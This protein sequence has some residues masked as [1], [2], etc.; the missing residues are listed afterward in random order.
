MSRRHL[1]N[2]RKARQ[3]AWTPFDEKWSANDLATT[4]TSKTQD[5]RVGS[6]LDC[7]SATLSSSGCNS[8]FNGHGPNGGYYWDGGST[9]G[10]CGGGEGGRG[11]G[12]GDSGEVGGDGGIG[13]GVGEAGNADLGHRD[14]DELWRDSAHASSFAALPSGP[15]RQF[16]SGRDLPSPPALVWAVEHD[17]SGANVRCG[18]GSHVESVRT[19]VGK[20]HTTSRLA[21]SAEISPP[22]AVQLRELDEIRESAKHSADAERDAHLSGSET[23]STDPWKDDHVFRSQN[24]RLASGCRTAAADSDLASFESST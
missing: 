22:A 16:Q 19:N 5:R 20:K 2:V 14:T 17:G 15:F 10:G 6:T 8:A 13:V 23:I 3:V 12:G 7:A 24:G 21:S 18:R 9:E 11:G 4:T 1:D